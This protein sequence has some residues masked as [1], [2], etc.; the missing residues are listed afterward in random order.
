MIEPITLATSAT[1]LVT[2][3][4]GEAAKA[5]AGQHGKD[6][7]GKAGAVLGWVRQQLAGREALADAAANLDDPLNRQ[8]LETALAKLL[9]DQP[10]LAAE[11]AVLVKEAGGPTISA[12]LEQKGGH[13][14]GAQ[15]VG[16]G[17]IVTIQR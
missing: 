8:A 12:H 15:A 2:P 9:R 1:A 16:T 5:G 6:A 4:L 3:L 7:A 14:T 13:N 11:L 10:T 17:N